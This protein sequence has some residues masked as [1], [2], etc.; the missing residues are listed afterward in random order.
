[1]IQV[2]NQDDEGLIQIYI[3]K[4]DLFKKEEEKSNNN[5]NTKK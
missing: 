2:L 4:F 3:F 1:M 5:D